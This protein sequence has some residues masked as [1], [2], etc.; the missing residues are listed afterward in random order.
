[1]PRIPPT[2][3]CLHATVPD[4]VN[5]YEVD[6]V[7]GLDQSGYPRGTE[8]QQYEEG[9]VLLDMAESTRRYF[10]ANT[11]ACATSCSTRQVVDDRPPAPAWKVSADTSRPET[12]S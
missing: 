9:T 8:V 11:V 2:S 5:V 7:A 6:R 4:R 10:S 12:R 3:R 1:M